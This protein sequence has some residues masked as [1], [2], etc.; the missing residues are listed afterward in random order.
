MDPLRGRLHT[1]LDA[2]LD[3]LD[4]YRRAPLEEELVRVRDVPFE[5]KARVEL[6]RSG[7]L[8][9]VQVGR[10]LWTKRSWVAACVEALPA[11]RS[12]EEH[13]ELAEAAQRRA[14]KRSA[15]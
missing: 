2:L 13:D 7:K 3:G 10:E 4:E 14:R 5:V 15:A 12:V 8:R 6:V 9:V 11:V 1:A